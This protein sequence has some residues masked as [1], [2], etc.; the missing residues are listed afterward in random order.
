MVEYVRMAKSPPEPGEAGQFKQQLASKQGRSDV[1]ILG[2]GLHSNLNQSAAHDW[3]DAVEGIINITYPW[4]TRHKAF[5]PRLF[6]TPNA[7][8]SNK[9]NQYKEMCVYRLLAL[10]IS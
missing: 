2:H 1:F 4:L 3:L 5:Y 6:M 8:G 10:F 9:P 7:A